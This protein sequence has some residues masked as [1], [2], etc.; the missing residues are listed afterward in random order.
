MCRSTQGGESVLEEASAAR[1]PVAD[2]MRI[3]LPKTTLGSKL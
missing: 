1:G 2:V 3:A